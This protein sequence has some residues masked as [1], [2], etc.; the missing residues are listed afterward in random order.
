MQAHLRW[1][2]RRRQGWSVDG[3]WRGRG[4]PRQVIG[5]S[6][7]GC[8]GTS[9]LC[10]RPR[11]SLGHGPGAR[12]GV[13]QGGRRGNVVHDTAGS[14]F[15]PSITLRSP[16]EIALAIPVTELRNESVPTARCGI[17]CT[18]ICLPRRTSNRTPVPPLGARRVESSARGRWDRCVRTVGRQRGRWWPPRGWNTDARPRSICEALYDVVI[19]CPCKTV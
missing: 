4:R 11:T 8:S 10:E 12:V 14:A 3:E 5:A 13:P 19:Y 17:F 9:G 1:S 6:Y 7:A 18:S 16:F 15:Q 2:G